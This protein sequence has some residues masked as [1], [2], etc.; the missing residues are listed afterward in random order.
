MYERVWE[1]LVVYIDKIGCF[2]KFVSKNWKGGILFLKYIIV[3]KDCKECG[4][5]RKF[6]VIIGIKKLFSN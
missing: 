3:V 1:L 4:N 5:L 6:Y 2:L